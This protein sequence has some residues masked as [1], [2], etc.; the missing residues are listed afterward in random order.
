MKD[1]LPGALTFGHLGA[2]AEP[3]K[4]R[5]EVK[6]E[7]R[8]VHRRALAGHVA[9]CIPSWCAYTHLGGRF[10]RKA[11]TPSMQSAEERERALSS[12]A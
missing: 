12:Q 5:P 1:R 8:H 4:V 11:A 7:L 9:A 3:V 2:I 10:S 6:G